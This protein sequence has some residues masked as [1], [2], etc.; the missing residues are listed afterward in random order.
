MI[1]FYPG[2]WGIHNIYIRISQAG[3]RYVDYGL[4]GIYAVLTGSS[5]LRCWAILDVNRAV[6][7]KLLYRG[8]TPVEYAISWRSKLRRKLWEQAQKAS[9]A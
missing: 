8:Q 1:G 3:G 5:T 2:S 4:W 7:A 9:Q 6:V